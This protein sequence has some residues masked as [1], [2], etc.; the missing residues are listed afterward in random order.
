MTQPK[1]NLVFTLNDNIPA[2][3]APANNAEDW[4]KGLE[5]LQQKRRHLARQ[6]QPSPASIQSNRQTATAYPS[7]V[8][9]TAVP[10]TQPQAA[11]KNTPNPSGSKNR[12]LNL[13]EQKQA[14]QAYLEHWQQQH[15]LQTADS[16]AELNNT[17]ILFQEDWLNA[18]TSLYVGH[19]EP[20]TEQATVWL[21]GQQAKVTPNQEIAGQIEALSESGQSSNP[22]GSPTSSDGMTDLNDTAALAAAA[23]KI[24]LLNV[25]A[26]PPQLQHKMLC[27]NEQT[28]LARLTEKLRPHLADAV[29]G[30]MKTALQ[31]QTALMVRSMQQEFLDDVPKLVDDILAYNLSRALAAVKKEQ[32]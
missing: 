17:Q 3:P 18:Q 19:N 8:P 11:H 6:N 7:A 13:A 23:E 16:E 12:R 14:Y 22:D 4:E 25:Y 9:A 10:A 24:V 20:V 28:L 31:K 26:P 1:D 15:N 2:S 21:G 30:M 32:L 27:L 29:A 5:R